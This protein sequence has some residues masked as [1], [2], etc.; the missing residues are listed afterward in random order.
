MQNFKSAQVLPF[1][2][3]VQATL[4]ATVGA[5]ATVNLTTDSASYF[6]L[7][8][9]GGSSSLDTDADFMPNN[10]TLSIIEQSTGRQITSGQIAQRVICGPSNQ[11]WQFRRLVNFPPN[12]TFQ[13]T[14]INTIATA[15]VVDVVLHGFKLYQLT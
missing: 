10:F 11:G 13:F 4:L 12:T 5:T 6:E 1:F 2:Y 3:V 15:N 14:V 8:Q 9:I 7:H